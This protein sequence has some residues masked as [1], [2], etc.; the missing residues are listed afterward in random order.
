MSDTTIDP[1][2]I[3]NALRSIPAAKFVLTC[4]HDQYSDG[5]ITYWVQQCSTVPPMVVV[6]IKKGQAIEPM[7]RD[8]RA[9]ALC[10]VNDNDRRVQRLFGSEHTLDDDPFPTLIAVCILDKSSQRMCRIR[11]RLSL[12]AHPM[13]QPMF[14][15]IARYFLTI[16][17][18]L[19][20]SSRSSYILI[21]NPSIKR[22]GDAIDLIRVVI[23]VVSFMLVRVSLARSSSHLQTSISSRAQAICFPTV[24]TPAI[25]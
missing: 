11:N 17:G 12:V 13:Y 14:L 16:Q 9:F 8:A 18:K 21:C 6:A 19:L 2:T 10:M 25:G 5:I 1:Q 20:P 23:S 4:T 15:N 7:L 24:G 3:H 22:D